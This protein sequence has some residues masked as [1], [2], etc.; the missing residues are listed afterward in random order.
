[1][2]AHSW[3]ASMFSSSPFLLSNFS[4]QGTNNQVNYLFRRAVVLCTLLSVL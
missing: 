3:P 1:M 4:K 2:L